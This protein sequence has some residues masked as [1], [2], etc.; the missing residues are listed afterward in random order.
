MLDYTLNLCMLQYTNKT[1]VLFF[2]CTTPTFT[3]IQNL[4]RKPLGFSSTYQLRSCLFARG[5]ESGRD[6]CMRCVCVVY[7]YI[8]IYVSN[9]PKSPRSQRRFIDFKVPSAA[10]RQLT[11]YKLIGGGGGKFRHL[12]VFLVISLL[13]IHPSIHPQPI[14]TPNKKQK[15]KNVKKKVAIEGVVWARMR[16]GVGWEGRKDRDEEGVGNERLAEQFLL[17]LSPHQIFCNSRVTEHP[18][19]P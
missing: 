12:F 14:S 5:G 6:A 2:P 7:V 18:P 19:S 15:T 16:R 10:P 17:P 3:Y 13:S 4:H 11:T 1:W 9:Q 8:C